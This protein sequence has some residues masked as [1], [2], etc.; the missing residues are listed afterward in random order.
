MRVFPRFLSVVL[1]A[2]LAYGEIPTKVEPIRTL[3]FTSRLACHIIIWNILCLQASNWCQKWVAGVRH[4]NSLVVRRVSP[5]GIIVVSF[6]SKYAV[7]YAV[8]RQIKP[9]ILKL[10]IRRVQSNFSIVFIFVSCEENGHYRVV[11]VGQLSFGLPLVL[12]AQPLYAR[13]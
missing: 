3:G 1:I 2:N 7:L 6:W 9:G 10:A 8:P 4:G 12:R 13:P 5:G 11:S